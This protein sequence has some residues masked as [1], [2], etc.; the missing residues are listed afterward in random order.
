MCLTQVQLGLLQKDENKSEE[1]FQILQ[2]CH[3]EYVPLDPES[4]VLHKI[5]LGGDHLTVE[6]ATSAV[7]AVADSDEAH[8]RLEG[9]ILKHEEFHCEMNF[10]Q[11]FLDQYF[12]THNFFHEID[13]YSPQKINVWYLGKLQ[14]GKKY[15]LVQKKK[16]LK[17]CT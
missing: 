1:I 9:I 6:R 8:E 14:P 4:N 5:N 12:H 16:W 17:P 7:N 13:F 11:V 3:A 15:E 2:H 10:L